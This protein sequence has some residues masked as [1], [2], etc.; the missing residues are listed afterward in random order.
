MAKP[1][2]PEE[3]DQIRARR[4]Y[5]KRLGLPPYEPNLILEPRDGKWDK[6]ARGEWADPGPAAT[7]T[8]Q[9]DP[10]M[11]TRGAHRLIQPGEI[12]VIRRGDMLRWGRLI[13]FGGSNRWWQFYHSGYG[14]AGWRD[15][16]PRWSVTWWFPE[17][18][19]IPEAP[20]PGE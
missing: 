12:I 19:P 8:I 2:T 16:V 5:D 15:F 13:H 14:Y 10:L 4:A 18:G 20:C 6:V 7:V 17:E 1:M 9:C 3:M 11:A